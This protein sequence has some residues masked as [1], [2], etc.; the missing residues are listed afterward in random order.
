MKTIE[1]M[2]NY[3]FGCLDGRDKSRLVKFLSSNQLE[4]FELSLKEGVIAE[5]FDK[6]VIPFTKENILIQL[7]EDVAFGFE[8]ALNKRG[9]SSSL[10]YDVVR[11]WNYILQEG[12]EDF[13]DYDHYGL[14]LFKATAIKY[15]FPNPIG[16]HTG[17]ESLFSDEDE[18]NVFFP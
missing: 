4:M 10:M 11:M 8:K 14:P 9:I 7:K 15:S 6:D 1:E 13:D 12:L 18:L 17:K 2:K 3:Q 16:K 5:E